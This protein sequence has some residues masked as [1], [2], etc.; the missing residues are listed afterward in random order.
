MT[1]PV[2]FED[3]TEALHCALHDDPEGA[4]EALKVMIDNH[5]LEALYPAILAW[6]DTVISVMEPYDQ[7]RLVEL[8]FIENNT[9]E[10][11]GAEEVPA[12]VAWAG[13]L[14]AARLADDRDMFQAL[15]TAVR[16]DDLGEWILTLLFTCAMNITQR[17]Q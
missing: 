7:A 12:P 3:A 6:I 10:V 9:E 17:A 14:L 15:A 4:V 5:G 2:W 8:R 13:R 11:T 16:Y 1:R